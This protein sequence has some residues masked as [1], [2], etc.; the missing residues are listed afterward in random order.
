MTMMILLGRGIIPQNTWG[1]N[2]KWYEARL[3]RQSQHFW[4]D[5][6]TFC[7]L[8][9]TKFGAVAI[10]HAPCEQAILHMM[11]S[12]IFC[13]INAKVSAKKEMAASSGQLMV[14]LVP[15]HTERKR[16]Q[17]QK[18]SKK[19]RQASKKFF[20]FTFTFAGCE[21]ALSFLF[22]KRGTF[23]IWVLLNQI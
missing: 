2:W 15:I 19:K 12:W 20:S 11:V 1:T 23:V 7:A 22:P 8:C 3:Q 4:P 21:W 18:R 14:L 16:R 13:Q 10:F 17:S 5:I 9:H 6:I